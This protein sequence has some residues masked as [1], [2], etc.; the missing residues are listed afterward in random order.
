VS[1]RRAA[2]LAAVT[3]PGLDADRR[4]WHLAHAAFGPDEEVAAELELSAARAQRRGGLAASAAFLERAV[5]LSSDLDRRSRRALA[6][7]QAKYLAGAPD[8]ARRLLLIAEAGPMGELERAQ[9]DM[10]RSGS[11]ALASVLSWPAP[12][13]CTASGC[14]G[15]TAA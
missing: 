6:A 14:A 11:A 10:I 15:S 7:A 5:Q 2:A 12:T 8:A 1:L 13:S 3:D 9:A 4:A